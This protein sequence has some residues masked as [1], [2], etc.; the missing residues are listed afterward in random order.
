MKHWRQVS[1]TVQPGLQV[2]VHLNPQQRPK[3]DHGQEEDKADQP[4]NN[5]LVSTARC[6][7]A[8]PGGLLPA[9]IP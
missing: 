6:W 4:P 9:P 8:L 7:R 1:D 3:Q 2:H 5:L